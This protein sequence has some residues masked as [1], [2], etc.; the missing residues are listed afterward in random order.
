M[1]AGDDPTTMIRREKTAMRRLRCSRPIALAL[2]QDII[3][4]E[5]S[6]FDYGCGHGGDLRYLQSRGVEAT[7]WDPHHAPEGAKV[8]AAVV[9]L[10]Y[11]LNVI[12]DACERRETLLRAFELAND[13]LAVA[14]R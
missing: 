13:V 9:N 8:P 5:T 4:P 11:V 12:E 7:G 1:A 3:R 10:G 6:V 2:A 14:V